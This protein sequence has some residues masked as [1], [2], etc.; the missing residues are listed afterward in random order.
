MLSEWSGGSGG[1]M[2][3]GISDKILKVGQNIPAH[4][5][6]IKRANAENINQR[7]RYV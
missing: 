6:R 5:E 4:E 1:E 7:K 3:R 2:V